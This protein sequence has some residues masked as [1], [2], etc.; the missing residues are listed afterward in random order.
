MWDNG[1]KY[2][3][4]DQVEFIDMGSLSGD[5]VFNMEACIV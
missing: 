5:S 4:I 1:K 2:I 3:K